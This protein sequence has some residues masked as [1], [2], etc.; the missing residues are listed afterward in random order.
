M[1]GRSKDSG[2]YKENKDH[3]AV[4]SKEKKPFIKLSRLIIH[5]A[6][7]KI[8]D[9]EERMKC[10][11]H[12][13]ESISHVSNRRHKQTHHNRLEIEPAFPNHVATYS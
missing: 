7:D 8:L 9:H 4:H 11:S 13:S 5:C 6:R 2:N 10:S 3:M 1:F 12:R